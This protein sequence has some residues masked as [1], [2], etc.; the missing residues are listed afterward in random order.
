M[1]E[2]TTRIPYRI[3]V[4][5]VETCNCEPG[6][7]C[8]F[9]GFPDHGSCEFICGIAVVEGTF[10]NV[11]LAGIRVV[12]VGK[13]PRAIHEGHGRGVLFIDESAAPE[14]V[15]GMAAILSGRMGGMPWEVL[16]TAGSL[17]DAVEGPIRQSIEMTIDGKRSHFRIPGILE[18][19][20]TP[21]KNP[22]TGEENEVH[23]VFPRG[24]LIWNDG[25]TATTDVM[26]INHGEIRL[27][28]PGQSAFYALTEWTNE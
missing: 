23:I 4:H 15:D 24:G 10:G 12:L 9:K 26:R 21:L 7:T 25:D 16:G 3:K 18:T 20:L 11:D 5:W 6:C 17:Y 19:R 8:N 28:H 14:Q 13:F 2:T 1:T 22:V 27:E